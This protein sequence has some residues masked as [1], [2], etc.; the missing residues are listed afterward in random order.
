MLMR[1]VTPSSN[2]ATGRMIGA[3]RRAALSPRLRAA[4]DPGGRPRPGR[5]R[6]A[7]MSCWT[8]WPGSGCPQISANAPG[9]TQPDVG[10]VAAH[11][12]HGV[13]ARH[14][15]ATKPVATSSPCRRTPTPTTPPAD[16]PGHAHTER[17]RPTP[18][19]S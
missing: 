18:T 1:P 15:P 10:R 12:E 7:S 11:R 3:A 19:S 6:A 13:S 4:P 5:C 14:R 17:R 8:G 9:W 2:T 16:R